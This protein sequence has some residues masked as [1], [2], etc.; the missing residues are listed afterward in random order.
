VLTQACEG[1]TA[2]FQLVPLT[3]SHRLSHGNAI[4]ISFDLHFG[5][6]VTFS[7]FPVA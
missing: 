6:S 3:I 7:G 1:V 4:H 2:L 5:I